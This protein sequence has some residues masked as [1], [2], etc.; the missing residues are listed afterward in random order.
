M[1]GADNAEHIRLYGKYCRANDNIDNKASPN[2]D[3]IRLQCQ[4]D[5][6]VVSIQYRLGYLGFWTTGWWTGTSFY[7][8]SSKIVRNRE[9]FISKKIQ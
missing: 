4:K 5:V 1:I 7:N 2:R 6:I 8:Y 3:R 9:E